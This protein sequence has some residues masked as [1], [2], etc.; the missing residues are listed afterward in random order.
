[1][2]LILAAGIPIYDWRLEE[3]RD[4]DGLSDGWTENASPGDLVMSVEAGSSV[5]DNRSYPF[6]SGVTQRIILSPAADQLHTG[7]YIQSGRTPSGYLNPGFN[8]TTAYFHVWATYSWE[9]AA[10]NDYWTM[11]IIPKKSSG[12][13]SFAQQTLNYAT[14]TSGLYVTTRQAFSKNVG[15]Y[16]DPDY[17]IVQI[18][19]PQ[20]RAAGAQI[21][22][23]ARIGIGFTLSFAS[24]GTVEQIATEHLHEGSAAWPITFDRD[25]GMGGGF[26]RT[27]DPTAGIKRWGYKINYRGL[28]QSDT[29]TIRDHWLANKGRPAIATAA[30]APV[31]Y[32]RGAAYPLIIE[33]GLPDAPGFSYVRFTNRDY[34]LSPDGTWQANTFRGTLEFEEV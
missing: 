21:L 26:P 33:T 2:G 7:R 13:A 15:Q 29:R 12:V 25:V 31:T 34:P 22:R 6:G 28:P 10:V 23:I 30:A 20:R 18:G 11:T 4:G 9:P 27:F 8:S 17:L 1:M 5:T 32:L 16:D 24:P 14:N 19:V 3:D